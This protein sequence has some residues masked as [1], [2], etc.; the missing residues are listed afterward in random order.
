MLQPWPIGLQIDTLHV[1][2]VAYVVACLYHVSRACAALMGHSMDTLLLKRS[3]FHQ[4]V[5]DR[6]GARCPF[7]KP[8]AHIAAEWLHVMTWTVIRHVL[9][10]LC[11]NVQLSRSICTA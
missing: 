6:Y 5:R 4:H 9:E 8:V 10:R 1:K 11:L 3:I 7:S 2:P